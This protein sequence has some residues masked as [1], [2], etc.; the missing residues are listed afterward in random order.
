MVSIYFLTFNVP[1]K[2]E[3]IEQTCKLLFK[4]QGATSDLKADR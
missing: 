2:G 4:E 3:K 1:D